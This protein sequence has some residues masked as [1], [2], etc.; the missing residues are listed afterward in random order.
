MAYQTIKK[1]QAT[2]KLR[3]TS[4]TGIVEK[5]EGQNAYVLAGETT[6]KFHI[7]ELTF[8]NDVQAQRFEKQA[9]TKVKADR[10]AMRLSE[11][12]TK[13]G[14]TEAVSFYQWSITS[15]ASCPFR[16]AMCEASC[17][18]LKAE[19]QYPAVK[20]RRD[21]NFEFSKS[22]EFVTTMIDQIAFELRRKKNK[23]K[24]IF[25]RIHEAGDFYSQD[26]MNKWVKIAHHFKGHRGIVFMAYTKSLPFVK[27]ALKKYGD[28]NVNITFKSSI[29]DDTKAKFEKMTN[30]LGMSVFTAMPKGEIEKK[31]FFPCPASE[32][33]KGTSKEKNCGECKV[34]YLG[35]VDVAIEIH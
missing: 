13:L 2:V 15:V 7:D 6:Y 34:C 32:A 11:G 8:F 31:G 18:S 17:Y 16:T 9:R 1:A 12:N 5:V 24:T 33:F 25:F 3:N 35:N 21:G 20:I 26:Y 28:N 29:W 4:I 10:I 22:D 23:G 14:N 27:Q 30:D 19:R